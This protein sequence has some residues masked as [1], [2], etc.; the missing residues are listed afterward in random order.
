MLGA[1]AGDIIGSV[2]EFSNYKATDFQPLI[3]ARARFTDDTVCTVAIADCILNDK[4]PADALREWCQRYWT[5][6]GW[7]QKYAK[8]LAGTSTEPYNSY[9]NG[10]AMRVS[11]CA[12][13]FDDYQ[14][15][16]RKAME[17]TAVTHNHPEGI[18][19]AMA[20][21]AAI[22][23]F[24]KQA[25]VAD[26]HQLIEGQFKYDL[27]RSVDA[28]REHNPHSEAAQDTVPEAVICAL[29]ATSFEDA[30]RNAISIGGD[31][32]TIGAIAGSIA[33]ARFGMA[34]ELTIEIA[35]FL[36]DDMKLVLNEFQ[37]RQ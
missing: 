9:G 36:P 22:F 3:H 12:W 18:R 29:Q 10:G 20:V 32:D 1:I 25:S 33:E 13:L 19:G 7:G 28:I 21:N 37:N 6:G 24:R 8:W 35:A 2:Y 23:C 30:I 15:S 11:P 26:V 17:V 14:E 27:S 5:N 31:S 4:A 34:A 16:M